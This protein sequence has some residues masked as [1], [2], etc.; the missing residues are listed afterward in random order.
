V[1]REKLRGFTANV[2]DLIGNKIIFNWKIPYTEF[3]VS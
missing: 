1:I 3:M 2:W